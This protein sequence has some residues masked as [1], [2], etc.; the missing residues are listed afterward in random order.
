[1]IGEKPEL[2]FLSFLYI[3]LF[4]FGVEVAFYDRAAVTY[5]KV[6]LIKFPLQSICSERTDDAFVLFICFCFFDL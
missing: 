4:E 1:M 5:N 6:N 3:K 2:V